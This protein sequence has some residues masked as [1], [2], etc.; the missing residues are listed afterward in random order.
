M[1]A[2]QIAARIDKNILERAGEVFAYYGLDTPSAIRMFITMTA[3]EREIPL[4][5]DRRVT[6]SQADRQ[7]D[8]ALS[9][10]EKKADDPGFNRHFMSLR[11]IGSKRPHTRTGLE[12]QLEARNEWPD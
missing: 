12:Q 1:A 11:G 5:I 4:R 8:E 7:M 10:A 3:N 6:I 2:V 9:L